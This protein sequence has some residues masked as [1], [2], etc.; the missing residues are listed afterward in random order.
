MKGRLCWFALALLMTMEIALA[1]MEVGDHLNDPI[2]C[3]IIR[4]E[5]GW[6]VRY[7]QTDQSEIN[8]I[9]H[10]STHDGVNLILADVQGRDKIIGYELLSDG[11][12][13]V[14]YRKL[15]GVQT[16]WETLIRLGR[17]G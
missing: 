7:G 17:T 10:I 6:N 16:E 8:A 11:A 9:T 3:L 15:G 13:R 2:P 14:R 5:N 4:F 12:V 1:D